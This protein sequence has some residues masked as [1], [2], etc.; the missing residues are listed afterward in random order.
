MPDNEIVG[1]CLFSRRYF[2]FP[3]ADYKT[4]D[5]HHTK[6]LNNTEHVKIGGLELVS[7]G[8]T[9][10][11]IPWCYIHIYIM[12]AVS[13]S[14]ALDFVFNVGTTDCRFSVLLFSPALL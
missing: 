12:K 1:S 4:T 11:F 3:F 13:R 8:I 7:L 6:Q 10:K 14:T 9:N 5:C 2:L